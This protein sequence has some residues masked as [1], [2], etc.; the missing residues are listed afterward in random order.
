VSQAALR[1]GRE[2][3]DQLAPECGPSRPAR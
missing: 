2:P 3:D 1:A